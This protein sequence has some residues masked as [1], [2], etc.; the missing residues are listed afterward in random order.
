M[1]TSRQIGFRLTAADIA[2]M[3]AAKEQ[4]GLPSRV[5]ALRYL[6]RSWDGSIEVLERMA[7]T[8][9]KKRRKTKR[10]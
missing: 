5:E 7:A 3:D 1:G 4:F 10:K 6:I 9:R 8:R 2:I